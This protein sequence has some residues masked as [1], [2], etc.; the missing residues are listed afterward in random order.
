MK[1]RLKGRVT[2]GTKPGPHPYLDSREESELV[3]YLFNAAKTGFGKMRQQIKYI[4][5]NVAKEKSILKSNHIS[6]GWWRRFLARQPQLALC[7]GDTTGHV[8][9]DAI[10]HE[11]VGNYYQLLKDVLEVNLPDTVSADRYSLTAASTT[12]PSVSTPTVS[13]S[14]MIPTT[15]PSLITPTVSPSVM[16]PIDG[17]HCLSFGDD[18][19]SLPFGDG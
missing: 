9:T 3:D 11:N 19:Q 14:V 1:D 15:L 7:R 17:S 12:I 8:R 2:H 10:N 5:E 13:P 16:I 18:L 4:A 6:N